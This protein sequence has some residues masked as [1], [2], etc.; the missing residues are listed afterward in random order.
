MRLGRRGMP[1]LLLSRNYYKVMG[2][3]HTLR[4]EL[5]S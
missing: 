2:T 5:Q 1:K 3:V 4:F